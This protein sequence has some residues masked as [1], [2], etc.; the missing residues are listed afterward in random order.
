MHVITKY[1]LLCEIDKNG[2]QV[3]ILW[4]QDTPHPSSSGNSNGMLTAEALWVASSH[5]G[6]YHD[7]LNAT[8]FL[9]WLKN[10]LVPCFERLFPGFSMVVVAD[11]APYH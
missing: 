6:D 10:K 11:N 7:N 5:H 9:F 2:V 8:M 4:K 3:D 1:G